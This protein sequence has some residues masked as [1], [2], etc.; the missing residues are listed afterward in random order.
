MRR[1]KERREV[2]QLIDVKAGAKNVAHRLNG[3]GRVSSNYLWARKARI[4][5]C[6][7]HIKNVYENTK[8]SD[9]VT[10]TNSK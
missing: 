6:L 2:Q 7:M 5:N 8:N 3:R 10:S 1:P 4:F 9:S